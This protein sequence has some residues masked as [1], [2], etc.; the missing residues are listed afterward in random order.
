MKKLKELVESYRQTGKAIPS[1]NIDTFEIYQS[2]ELAVRETALPCLV[3]LSAGEDA[4]IEAERL[5]MLVQKARLEALPIYLNMDHGANIGRLKQ[6]IKLGFDMVHF[7]GSKLDL[8]TNQ[9]LAK[10]L[11]EFAHYYGTLV[12]VE[13]DQIKLTENQDAV[14]LTSPQTAKE[15]IGITSADFFAVSIGNKHGAIANQPEFIDLAHLAKIKAELPHTFLTLHGGSGID[16]NQINAAIKQ[17][18]VKININTDLRHAF[19]NSLNKHI[20][21]FDSDRAY[22]LLKPV[23]ADVATVVKQKLLQF[24]SP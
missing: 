5:F 23:V 24:S 18:I 8:A 17:G 22:E 3:Q 6:L 7:D 10:D 11:V 15:F 21:T 4:F 9:L 20:V 1:F 14:T 19:R 13:F 16:S 12:E 2:V